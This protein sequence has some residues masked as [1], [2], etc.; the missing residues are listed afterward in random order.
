MEFRKTTILPTDDAE[1]A[2]RML[3]DLVYEQP[4]VLFVV[5]GTGPEAEDLVQRAA[6][7]SGAESEPR[8][9]VWIRQPVMLET[10]IRNFS[11]AERL[12]AALGH[13]RAFSMSITDAIRDVMLASDGVP[14]LMRVLQAYFRAEKMEEDA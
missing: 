8:W 12:P 2:G 14:N 7:L 13:C 1:L 11:G 3:A 9:V 6:K 10:Q 4:Y 5:L